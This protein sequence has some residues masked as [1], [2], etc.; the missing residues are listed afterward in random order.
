MGMQDDLDMPYPKLE[1]PKPPPGYGTDKSGEMGHMELLF[2][3]LV[4]AGFSFMAGYALAPRAIA[5]NTLLNSTC[6]CE[7]NI[8]KQGILNKNMQAAHVPMSFNN[9]KEYQNAFGISD[10]GYLYGNS[11]QPT[12]FEGNTALQ[13]N[14]TP[15][16]VLR[17]GMLVRF[18]RGNPKC[19]NSTDEEQDDFVIHRIDGIYGED[20]IIVS[21]DNTDY[22]ESIRRCQISYVVVGIIFS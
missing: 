19:L 10:L 21:G 4:I 15:G 3:L 12:F 2:I 6:Q 16:F 5:T 11:M 1:V 9:I 22:D 13:R 18:N 20:N 14:L 7:Y 8:Q 17:P